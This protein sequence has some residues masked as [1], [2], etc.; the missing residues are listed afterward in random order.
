MVIYEAIDTTTQ[1]STWGKFIINLLTK[2]LLFNQT[3]DN[4]FTEIVL[5]KREELLCYLSQDNYPSHCTD[6]FYK[7]YK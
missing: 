7:K 5:A 1:P 6:I 4:S 3:S 2:N